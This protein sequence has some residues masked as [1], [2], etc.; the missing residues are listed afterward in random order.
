MRTK[1]VFPALLIVLTAFV[2]L[3][4]ATT[5][6]AFTTRG[7]ISE[8]YVQ[9]AK[10]KQ[11][12][13]LLDNKS[14]AVL[15]TGK[16]D[17][18]GS[19][20][21]RDLRQGAKY[22]VRIGS[23]SKSATVLKAGDNPKES[24][25]KKLPKLKAGL[26]YVKMRDGVELAMTVRLP[27]GK[28]LADGPFPTV[29]EYSGYQ[30]AAP[31]DLLSS[32][33]SGKP[34][35]LA[36]ET[37]TIIGSALAPLLGYASI[38]VQM[39]GSGCSGGAFDLFDL[40]TTYDGYDAV[41]TVA[42]QPWV[43]GG[44]VGLVGISFSG[45]S[46]IFVA[47]ARPPHL[48]AITPMSI[49][50]D[51]YSATGYPGG[52]F[53]KGFALS[54]ITDRV[55]DAKP[56]PEGGQPY[57][58]ELV[59]RGDKNC[60]ANQKLRLQT[61][62][63]LALIRKNPYRTPSLFDDRAPEAWMSKINVPTFLIGAFHDEQTGAHFASTLDRLADND[64]TWISL[65]NGT[66][67]DSLGPSTVTRWFEFL[68]LYVADQ[69]PALPQSILGLSSALYG[70]V[71]GAAAIPIEQSRFAKMTDVN[72]A[73]AQFEKDARVTLLMDNGGT[74][75]GLGSMGAAWTIEA[76]EWPVS[77]ANAASYYLGSGG[78]LSTSKPS[79]STAAYKSDTK[80]RPMQTLAGTGEGDAWAGQPPYN[81]TPLVSGKGLGWATAPLKS[82]VVIAG[83]SSF[84][85]Y[86]K[87]SAKDTDLQ[88]TLTEIRPDGKETYVQNGWLRASHRKLG[89]DS[90]A[91]QPVPTHLKKDAAPLP[92]GKYTLVR[93]PLLPVAHAFRAGSRIR[94]TLEAPGGDRPR[95]AFATIEKGK[96]KNTV[97][98]GGARASK[99]VLPVLD[100]ANAK[101]TPLPAPTT[102]RGQPSRDYVAAA[103]G[104]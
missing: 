13:E 62:D 14:G 17:R 90:T 42:A 97:A 40:P 9:D 58:R 28:T 24:F 72:A 51:L 61:Q 2:A 64:R 94:V 50:D 55:Q 59:K 46:Q 98:L 100:G 43:K 67:V 80:A 32:I 93:V 81:W 5:A 34:D 65:I 91:L 54:W 37:G 26:N 99:L 35:P 31:N 88:V 45:I 75:A 7:S 78:S 70:Q 15:K 77:N 85:V 8:I 44:M 11:K 41:E 49:T 47:G 92:S 84:D 29:I 27:S 103:N 82:D 38:S 21:F 36:P 1:P 57:A 48:A 6:S 12:V 104:G 23:S 83:S 68:E 18:L 63:V 66:H 30:I 87:S 89:S 22:K 4:A 96:T 101:G 25:Y 95:W 74:S 76:D 20:I 53:N 33:A 39:R 102:L 56:A 3:A 71:S 10:A 73:R 79:G 86:L 52:I 60:A 16:V 19:Y 69:V